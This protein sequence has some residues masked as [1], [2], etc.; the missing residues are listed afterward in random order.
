MIIKLLRILYCVCFYFTIISTNYFTACCIFCES[1]NK[2]ATK[3]FF[4][5]KTRGWQLHLVERISQV[6]EEIVIQCLGKKKQQVG[7]HA[8]LFQ[9]AIQVASVDVHLKSELLFPNVMTIN[10]VVNQFADMDEL[11]LLVLFFFVFHCLLY[12]QVIHLTISEMQK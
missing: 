12:F 11:A 10:L 5:L 2:N 3:H 6:A 1:F 7:I 4:D 8:F 9:D